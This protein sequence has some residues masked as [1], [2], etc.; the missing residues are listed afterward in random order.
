MK[1]ARYVIALVALVAATSGVLRV[2][3]KALS[4]SASVTLP[5]DL[6]SFRQYPSMLPIFAIRVHLAGSTDIYDLVDTAVKAGWS[7]S[8]LAS[9][10]VTIQGSGRELQI[11]RVQLIP[12]SLD[13]SDKP[14]VL[15]IMQRHVAASDKIIVSLQNLPGG[16]KAQSNPQKFEA[17]PGHPDSNLPNSWAFNLTPQAAPNESLTTGGKRDVGQLSVTIAAPDIAPN[18]RDVAI[19]AKSTDLFSTDER[20]SQSAFSSIL[21]VTRGIFSS[22]YS[23]IHFEEDIKGNQVATSLSAV[24]TMGF[25]T[26]APWYWSRHVLNNRWLDAPNPPEFNV[27]SEYTRRINQNVRAVN[28]LLSK[29]DFDLN[30]SVTFTPIFLFPAACKWLDNKLNAAAQT[31]SRQYCLGLDAD[32]GMWYLPLDKTKLGSQRAE[33]YGDISFLIPLSDIP[34]KFVANLVSNNSTN[35]QIRIKYADAVNSANNYA[36][37]KEW[38]LGI[39]VIK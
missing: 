32:L 22:W 26:L 37:S 13:C 20:D 14:D 3:A 28:Q 23:P 35:S 21:G 1:S 38:T 4:D 8:S 29:N 6:R 27:N 24:T 5:V 15:L 36:R 34:F 30:P 25:S 10:K 7:C 11:S 33:G 16:L 2:W 31:S 39:E 18:V 17:I 9:Y 12:S 19:Y